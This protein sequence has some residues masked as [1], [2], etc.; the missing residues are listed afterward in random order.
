VI[1]DDIPAN[2]HPSS[3]PNI[4]VLP[5]LVWRTRCGGELTI[6]TVKCV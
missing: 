2:S 4:I 6:N 5:V 1:G 3:A